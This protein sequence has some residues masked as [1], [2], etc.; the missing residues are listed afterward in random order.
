MDTGNRFRSCVLGVMSPARYLCAMPAKMLKFNVAC[1]M[2]DC[3][4]KAA[5]LEWIPAT[6]FD[7][8]SSEL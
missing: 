2:T 7:P 4:C 5:E 1:A 6:G 8:V 3:F